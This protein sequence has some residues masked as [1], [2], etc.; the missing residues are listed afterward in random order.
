M[1]GPLSLCPGSGLVHKRTMGAL[2][3]TRYTLC[4]RLMLTSNV[5]LWREDVK[6]WTLLSSQAHNGANIL[7]PPTVTRTA[8]P[9]QHANL[10]QHFQRPR[11]QP[12]IPYPLPHGDLPAHPL[13][14]CS[15]CLLAVSVR[16]WLAFS[17]TARYATVSTAKAAP[18]SL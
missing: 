15:M 12:S 5:K 8:H 7:K 18:C 13:I 10:S 4:K 17:S 9:R 14:Y 11:Q 16:E 3:L 2:E 1:L 6:V